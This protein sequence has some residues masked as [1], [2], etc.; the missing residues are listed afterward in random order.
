MLPDKT[1]EPGKYENF[2]KSSSGKGWEFD[3]ISWLLQNECDL[4]VMRKLRI[5]Y[6]WQ[7]SIFILE[8]FYLPSP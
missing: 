1:E 4:H 6:N 7:I 3:K 2:N 8:E 5:F